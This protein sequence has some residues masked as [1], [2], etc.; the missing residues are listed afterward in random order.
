MPRHPGLASTVAL[1]TVTV[2][3]SQGITTGSAQFGGGTSLGGILPGLNQVEQRMV[4][5][6]S[7]E[8]RRC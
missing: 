2:T 6:R 3:A 1:G 5:L 4:F 8:G 7:L